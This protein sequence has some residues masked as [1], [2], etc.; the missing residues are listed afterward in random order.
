LPPNIPRLF[1]KQRH[2]GEIAIGPCSVDV[3]KMFLNFG[4][5]LVRCGFTWQWLGTLWSPGRKRGGAVSRQHGPAALSGAG[6]GSSGAPSEE[7]ASQSD[8]ADSGSVRRPARPYSPP[9][10][11]WL[12]PPRTRRGVQARRAPSGAETGGD[13]CRWPRR[14]TIQGGD[15]SRSCGRM[16]DWATAQP[17]M[18]SMDM[19]AS[20]DRP[21]DVGI[22]RRWL[23]S[24]VKCTSLTPLVSVGH[25]SPVTEAMSRGLEYIGPSEQR[26]E[27]LA[28]GWAHGTGCPSD[29]CD[30]PNPRVRSQVLSSLRQAGS[31]M[32]HARNVL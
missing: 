15:G 22:R 18:R 30:Y 11:I 13:T 32:F 10:G 23:K 28:S 12:R 26:G 31:A 6:L 29:A 7:S 14:S 25:G 8:G 5:W 3:L 21:A 1:W 20:S 17:S 19:G 27:P 9:G 16:R 2:E 4:T 24:F